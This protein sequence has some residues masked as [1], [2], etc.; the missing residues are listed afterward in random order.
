MLLIP[1]SVFF[2]PVVFALELY[3]F[4]SVFASAK[5]TLMETNWKLPVSKA[6]KYTIAV[7]VVFA[8]GMVVILLSCFV[9][10]M[11]FF[12]ELD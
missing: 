6:N 7:A 4:Y 11:S 9:F 10:I 8:L 3:V 5:R 12:G 2:Q 1:A